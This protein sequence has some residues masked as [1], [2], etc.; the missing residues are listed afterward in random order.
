MDKSKLYQMFSAFLTRKTARSEN[1]EMDKLIRHTSDE[2]LG[3][4]LSDLWEDYELTES[5]DSEIKSIYKKLEHRIQVKRIRM[6][7]V[8]FAKYAAIVLIPLL[9]TLSAYLIVERNNY[10]SEN[11]YFSVRV[12]PGQSSNIVLPDGSKVMLNSQSNIVYSND[13]KLHQRRVTLKGEAHFHVTKNPN[14]PFVVGTEFFDVE[15]LGTTFNVKTY[16]SDDIQVV[17]LLEGKVKLTTH[18]PGKNKTIYLTPNQ[19]AIY[20][21]NT[22]ELSVEATDNISETAWM[23]GILSFQTETL[24]NIK[25]DLERKYNVH[26]QMNCPSIENDSFTGDFDNE[27]LTQI[28]DDLKIHYG[29]DYSI[30]KNNVHIFPCTS[31]KNQ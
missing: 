1:K 31:S 10:R 12:D 3:S 28:L 15:V 22:G 26:I 19:K 6:H 13:F 9:S 23:K 29:F 25:L 4:V 27:T 14:R 17:G 5:Y 2:E 21:K 24:H 30:T 18:I 20:N 8:R 7:S 11:S 16:E